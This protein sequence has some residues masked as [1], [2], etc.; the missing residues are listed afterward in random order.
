MQTACEAPL[1]A[2]RFLP[3]PVDSAYAGRDATSRRVYERGHMRSGLGTGFVL[4]VTE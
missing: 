4:L 3:A 1:V 2:I